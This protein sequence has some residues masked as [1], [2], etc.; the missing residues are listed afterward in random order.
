[1]LVKVMSIYIHSL[2]GTGLGLRPVIGFCFHGVVGSK[3]IV[4]RTEETNN[5]NQT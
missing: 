5:P 4:G 3:T 2:Y 1:M